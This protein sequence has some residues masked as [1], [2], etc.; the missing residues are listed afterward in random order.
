MSQD[1]TILRKSLDAVDRRRSYAIIAVVIAVVVTL[2][3]FFRL[4]QAFSS[5]ADVRRLLQLS[6]VAM[7]FWT[8]GLTVIVV[9]QLAAMTRRVL[10]AIELASKLE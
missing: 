4:A 10:R 2:G 6:L 5:D 9:L 7:I 8:S 1:D 3:A